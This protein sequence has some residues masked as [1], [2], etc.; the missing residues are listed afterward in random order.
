MPGPAMPPSLR[1]LED[2][3]NALHAALRVRHE[4]GGSPHLRNPADVHAAITSLSR[5]L[6]VV[7]TVVD[8]L[9]DH[10]RAWQ[11]RDRLLLTPLTPVDHTV[12]EGMGLILLAAR[13]ALG[14]QEHTVR[15]LASLLTVLSHYSP[16][17]AERGPD[18][19]S[20]SQDDERT[21]RDAIRHLQNRVA[22]NG[23][24]PLNGD[25]VDEAWLY[26]MLQVMGS[27]LQTG[28]RAEA[29]KTMTD[30]SISDGTWRPK[31]LALLVDLAELVAG[32]Q[33][34]GREHLG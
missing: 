33:D 5:T 22:R 15:S 4:D 31:L 20:Y 23:V 13:S 3:M 18:E 11:E 16:N 25:Y 32:V 21:T 27:A 1:H 2:D 8:L 28:R 34:N 7:P 6:D 19:P 26:L 30:P 24:K 12:E 14:A 29:V 10:L 9:V 17:V